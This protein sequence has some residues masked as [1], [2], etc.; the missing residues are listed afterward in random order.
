MPAAK[1][2]VSVSLDA[3][4]ADELGSNA[5]E[6]SRQVNDAVREALERRRR[7]RALRELLAEL[8]RRHG[9]VPERLIAKF[10][11]LLA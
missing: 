8:D 6:V 7:Q 1:R 2:K 10:E 11:A 5:R 3:D 9:P 4:L